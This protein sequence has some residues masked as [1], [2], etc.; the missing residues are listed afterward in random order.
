MPPQKAK[1]VMKEAYEHGIFCVEL[2]GGE[3]SIY[4]HKKLMDIILY[5]RSLGQYV[6][7]LTNCV[8][9]NEE[10]ARFLGRH[11]V[12]VRVSL[13]GASEETYQRITGKQVLKRVVSSLKLLKDNGVVTIIHPVVI[14]GNEHEAEAMIE[15]ASN[16]TEKNMVS[17]YTTLYESWDR[18]GVTELQI[19]KTDN[20]PWGVDLNK[21]EG[22]LIARVLRGEINSLNTCPIALGLEIHPDGTVLQCNFAPQ[23]TLGNVFKEGFSTIIKRALFRNNVNIATTPPCMQFARETPLLSVE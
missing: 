18:R 13:Y 4:N 19:E 17:I 1:E 15:L 6:R 7:L 2:T 22:S 20:N 11:H 14:K 8:G 10:L 5:A 12:E 21:T 16:F 9:I 3:I 23:V